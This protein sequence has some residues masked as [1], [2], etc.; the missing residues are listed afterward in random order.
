MEITDKI[1]TNNNWEIT[2]VI[3]PLINISTVDKSL[4]TFSFENTSIN[5][6]LPEDIEKYSI[7]ECGYSVSYGIKTDT[8][9]LV[10]QGRG[11]ALVK[12]VL[13]VKQ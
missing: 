3:N 5:I 13:E 1:S 11:N 10:L 4:L 6:K 7:K 2:F 8:K 9:K 12:T